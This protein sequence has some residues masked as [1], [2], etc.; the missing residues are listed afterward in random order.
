MDFHLS[1]EQIAMQNMVFEFMQE[2][3]MPQAAAWDENSLFPKEVL[4]HAAQLGLAGICINGDVGGSELTR[5]DYVLIFEILAQACPSTASYLSIHNMVTGLIDQFG[6]EEQRHRF[7]PKL[8]TLEHFSS[9]CLTEPSTGSDAANLKT[10]ATRDGNHYILNGS[11]AFISGAGESDVYLCMV[12]TGVEGAKGISCI[13]VEKDTP[14]FSIGKKEVKL[15]WHSQPTAMLFFENCR[16]PVTNR[17]GAEGQ[18]FNIALSA[19]NSGRLGIAACSLGGASQCFELARR[20]THERE[21]F[22]QP[23]SHFQSIQFKLADMATQLE[24]ARLTVY[25]AAFS[26]DKKE[27]KAPTYVA[28]AKQLATDTGF[29]VC[30]E[31]LQLHGG[32]G[33]LRD[34]PIERY[35]RDLR[36]HQILEGTNEIMRVIIAKSLL[37]EME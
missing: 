25:R 37:K 22:K 13:V 8:T 14:G 34:Y 20:Y 17:I 5:L 23:L 30:N 4:R 26:L 32:Y 12:R 3:M 15:G 21:Q 11:K 33:Y 36:V 19:L 16:V 29:T 7:I 31:A 10:T 1:S 2:Q 18:G 24:A 6:S 28:M 35:L 27:D 9:Y